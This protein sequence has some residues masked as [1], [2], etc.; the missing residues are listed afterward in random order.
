MFQFVPE[1][2]RRLRYLFARKRLEAELREEMETHL[3]MLAEDND[4]AHGRQRLGNVTRWSEISRSVWGWNWLESVIGDVQYGLRLLAKSPGFTIAACLSLALGLGATIGIFSLM[5]ALLFK[6]LPVL[7]PEQLWGLAHGD[8]QQEEDN[9]SYPMFSELQRFNNTGVPFFAVGGDYVQVDYGDGSIRNTPTM[10]VSGSA[11]QI[12]DVKAYAGRM[13]G[14]DDDIRGIPHGANCIV[15]YRLW[16]SQF[17]GDASAIGGHITIG[18]QRFTIVGIAPPEFFGVYVGAYSDLILPITA[19]AATNPA[20]PLLDAPKW[21]WLVLTTRIPAGM[22][23]QNVAAGLNTTYAALRRESKFA[24]SGPARADPLY[25]KPLAQGVSAIRNRFAKPLYVLLT[26]TGL[27]LLIAC[28][29]IANLLLARS[30]VRYREV[31]VRLSLGAERGRVF[32][33]LLTESTLVALLGAIASVP[34]YLAC[35]KGLLAFLQSG[36]DSDIF[37]NTAPDWRLIAAGVGIVCCTVLLFGFAP[38][39]RVSRCDLNMA[40]SENSQR[41]AAKTSFGKFVVGAQIGFSLV[42]LLGAALLSRSLY[43]LR[44]FDPGFRRDHLLIA[45]VDTTQ[46]IHKNADVVR[47]FDNLLER[48]RSLPGVRSAAASKVVPLGGR[49]WQN[50]YELDQDRDQ[51]ANK[52]HSYLN[53]VTPEY[54]QTL[55]TPLVLGRDFSAQDSASSP[56]VAIVNET[57]VKR[58]LGTANP[59]ARRFF[60][61]TKGKRDPIQIIGIVRDARYRSLTDEIPPTVYRP[62][63]QL[64]T[65]FDFLLELSLEVWTRA[66]ARDLAGPIRSIPKQ[67]DAQVSTEIRT[68]DSLIDS[69]L[70]YQRMLTA[71]SIA[72]GAVGLVLSAIGVFGLSAYAVGRRTPELGIRMALGST[73]GE[74]LRLVLSEHLRLL[75]LGLAAGLGLSVVLTRFL[76]AWLFGVSATDPILFG[77]AILI[78]SAIALGA[79]LVPARRAARLNPVA[80]L[81]HE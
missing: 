34:V 19:Y 70:L 53:W 29:N 43:D 42:L 81:R 3:T 1:I 36:A 40:L 7:H 61:I 51:S 22:T 9:F 49:T 67:L 58:Y 79:A 24:D 45:D 56:R 59:I 16:Q 27:I 71:L 68:F 63:E 62:I 25:L 41:L 39:L 60:E 15:S 46:S 12:L 32:R 72:F 10:L 52:I 64:P 48:V 73:P 17:R 2:A 55:G 78:L 65:A 35:T 69:N 4:P 77:A 47:F 28:A 21:T 6:P 38:A 8:P 33:Q 13:L 57:F 50:D 44:T 54:F 18:Q 14:P 20:Q 66:P 76:R 31:A 80:A 23:A 75:G 26:M 11:F 37:L 30:V 74:I 5:N